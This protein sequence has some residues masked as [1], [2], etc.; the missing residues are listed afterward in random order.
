MMVINSDVLNT[1]WA[2]MIILMII[3]KAKYDLQE[4][5]A[6]LLPQRHRHGGGTG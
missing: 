1:M 5:S 6:A 2:M 3:L 4:T